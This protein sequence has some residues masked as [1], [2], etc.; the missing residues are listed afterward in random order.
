LCDG[1]NLVFYPVQAER[2]TGSPEKVTL[3]ELTIEKKKK[4]TAANI[5]R[6]PFEEENY[7]ASAWSRPLHLSFSR[8]PRSLR[9]LGPFPL[10][11]VSDM[12]DDL[13]KGKALEGTVN[14]ILLRLQ[15]GPEE[16]CSNMKC[17]VSCF[18]VLVTPSGST[19]RL[20][21]EEELTKETENSFDMKNPKYRTPVLVSSVS[22]SAA[23]SIAS[24]Y[25]YDPP[26]GW[27]I[28]G[29]G[30][31]HNG[32]T[33]PALK[34]G[35][36]SF[37]YVDFYRPAAETQKE[38]LFNDGSFHDD[39]V[40]DFSLCK[41]DFYV[42]LTYRQERPLL[43]KKQ[44]R[45]RRSSRRRPVMSSSSAKGDTSDNTDTLLANEKIEDG[46]TSEEVS[47]EYT[48]S[49]VWAPPISAKFRLS[50]RKSCPC[51]SRHPS[52]RIDYTP[53]AGINEECILADG[54]SVCT[55]CSLQLNPSMDGLKTEIVAVRF[56]V[57][58]VIFLYCKASTALTLP[59][60]AD[61]TRLGRTPL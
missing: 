10:L 27:K 52:N 53:Q 21:S 42:T 20:V 5:K 37:M 24:D 60:S 35:E 44:N 14:R 49:V 13:T 9:V 11:V 7:I 57:S 28:S 31:K 45:T 16:R 6:T 47:L 39:D 17:N 25:G 51:G 29:S 22:A 50:A 48:G 2:A 30:Q 1:L 59:F 41:T 15:A 4:R 56:A 36:S 34:G 43:Q 46:E 18:S 23:H 54:Q 12:T 40:A 3:I 33:L 8:G 58:C 19:K 38:V 55:R 26:K 32:M 61:R